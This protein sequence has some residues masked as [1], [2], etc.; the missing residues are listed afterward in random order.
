MLSALRFAR[1]SHQTLISS[2]VVLSTIGV[3][4]FVTFCSANSSKVALN[5]FRFQ[6]F[7]V[8]K[9]EE[10]THDTKRIVFDLPGPDYEMGLSVASFV[11]VQADI[12]GKSVMRPYTPVN[13]NAEK[14]VIELVVKGYPTGQMS[15]HIMGLQVGDS[16]AMMG[17]IVKFKYEPNKYKKIGLIAGGSGLTPL[18]QVTKE[19][20]RNPGDKTEVTLVF[21]NRTEG[22]II[23]HDELDALQDKYPQLKVHYVLSQPSASWEGLKGHVTKEILQELLPGPSDDHLVCVCGPP[24]MMEAISGCMGWFWRQGQLRGLLKELEYTSSQV[25]KL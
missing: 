24:P 7:K 10:A 5:Q 8:S 16:L 6:T 14:G 15:K 21:A 18:L 3:A 9:I 13:T 4:S 1:P 17:P 23:L 11:L 22:D 2:A 19:I 25:Y 12:N 20:L